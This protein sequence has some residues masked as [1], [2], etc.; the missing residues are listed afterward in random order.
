MKN[1]FLVALF[2]LSF[3]LSSSAATEITWVG[4]ASGD[5]QTTANWDP[6][7]VPT[8]ENTGT[9]IA[10]FTNSATLTRSGYWYPAGVRVTGSSTVTYTGSHLKAAGTLERRGGDERRALF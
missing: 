5:V 2:G 8:G 3:S 10:V 9:Y 4:G 6:Q 7:T 1:V